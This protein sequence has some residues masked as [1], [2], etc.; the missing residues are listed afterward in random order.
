VR[1]AKEGDKRQARITLSFPGWKEGKV[2]PASFTVPL[3]TLE[4]K[5]RE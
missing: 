5:S 1:A 2:Q 4:K 3:V